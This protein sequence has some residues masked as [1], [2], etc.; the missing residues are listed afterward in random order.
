MG[1]NGFMDDEREL[2]D[3]E[4]AARRRQLEERAMTPQERLRVMDRLC[5]DL[6]RLAAAAR[7]G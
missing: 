6:T 4:A 7:R 1:H 3:F 5:R 2:S